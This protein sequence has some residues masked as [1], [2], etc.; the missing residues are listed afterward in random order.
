MGGS[1]ASILQ[2]PL[3]QTPQ[4]SPNWDGEQSNPQLL[5]WR[6]CHVSGSPNQGWRP[7]LL[8]A[9][10][11]SHYSLALQ[12]AASGFSLD[13]AGGEHHNARLH[14]HSADCLQKDKPVHENN[15]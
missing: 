8:Q 15:V 6:H 5:K 13:S 9:S 11:G 3:Q 2:Q 12:E 4:S 14:D 1:S 7:A 10:D